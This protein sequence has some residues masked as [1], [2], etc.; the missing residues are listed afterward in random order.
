[1]W[2]QSTR[3]EESVMAELRL[4]RRI[5]KA[6]LMNYYKIPSYEVEELINKVLTA[7]N[8]V[9]DIARHSRL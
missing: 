4:L 5:A 9:R 7:Y 1:M 3:H 8:I 6:F 2:N